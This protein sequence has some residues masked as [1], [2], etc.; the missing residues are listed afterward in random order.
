MTPLKDCQICNG[1]GVYLD[2]T[3]ECWGALAPVY[4]PC[5]CTE[6]EEDME[7]IKYKIL[8]DRNKRPTVTICEIRANGYIGKGIAIRSLK[9]N[10]VKATGRKLAEGRARKALYRSD[11]SMPI[12]RTEAFESLSAVDS[13]GLPLYKSEYLEA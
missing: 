10:P 6:R 4:E 2:R 13:L 5:P 9:D 3:E 11:S 1:R 12:F 7:S 8:R